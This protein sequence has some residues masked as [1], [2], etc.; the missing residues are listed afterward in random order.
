MSD[1]ASRTHKPTPTRVK[2]FRKRGEIAQSREL[3]AMGALG[4]GLCGLAFGGSTTWRAFCDLTRTAA[5]GGSLDAVGAAARHTFAVAVG[6]VLIAA[7]VG[8][9]VVGGLQLGW[10]PALKMPGF[11]I[12]KWW[13]FGGAVDALSPRAMARRLL[14]AVAKVAAIGGV[15]A[16]VVSS[17]IGEL[18]AISDPT[19]LPSRLGGA[20][21]HLVIVATAALAGIAAV[22]Y[23]L[24]KRRIGAKMMM[25]PDELRR[26]GREQEGDP[27]V[28]G[29]RR[30][31]MRELSRRRLV[32]ETQAA[33][34]VL[35]NPTH[36]A[37]ALRYDAD[38]G[39]APRVVAK[40]ADEVAMRIR[41][42][43]RAAGVPV[44]SRPPLT[45]ALYKLCPEGQE[46]PPALFHAV[47]EVLAYVYRLRAPRAGVSARRAS[48]EGRVTPAP[49]AGAA[50]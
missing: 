5:S 29:Q 43:A 18:A 2:E 3:T 1:D 34:V 44:V 28:K 49:R 46:I 48:S 37:V 15:V 25:T 42:I 32:T 23:I 21:L 39:G 20:A 13:S 33:D 4:V 7:M 11:D 40:G 14:A 30:R 50:S 45:R 6:P 27:Q 47:A 17:Q 24:A 16:M 38:G 19:T 26:E 9:V 41:E 8:C 31:R 35:V 12:T 36:Y 10:P 22:D